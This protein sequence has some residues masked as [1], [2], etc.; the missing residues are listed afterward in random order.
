[1]GQKYLL[2]NLFTILI[3]FGIYTGQLEFSVFLTILLSIVLVIIRFVL[4]AHDKV[5]YNVFVFFI[6]VYGLLTLFTHIELIKNPYDDFFVHNDAAWSFYKWT[7]DEVVPLEWSQLIEGTLLNPAFYEYFLAELLFGTIAKIAVSFGI[8]DVRL[9]LRCLCFVMGA[10]INTIIA[11]M[12]IKNKKSPKETFKNILCFGCISYLYITS[13]VFSR[14][15]FVCLTYAAIGYVILI[16]KCSFR[17]VKLLLLSFCAF[18]GRPENG[19][20]A[21]VFVIAYYVSLRESKIIN[22]LLTL[23]ILLFIAVFVQYTSFVSDSMESLQNFEDLTKD[24]TGG[25]FQKVYS[26]PFPINKIAMVIYMLLQPLPM[27]KY[28][29]G[30][31][32]SWFTLPFVLSPYMIFLVIVCCIWFIIKRSSINKVVSYYIMT[33]I[34]GFCLITFVSPDLRRSF[35]T[36]PGLFGAYCLIQNEI[37]RT[38]INFAKKTIWPVLLITSMFFQ[39]Y[40]MTK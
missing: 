28:I 21:I 33:S 23:L 9:A 26:L 24:N 37:P 17:F 7:M 18:G 39:I 2:F 34:L 40:I 1:M 5:V 20:F 36:I 13:A 31:G 19:V 32:N 6:L 10:F 30:D 14:D 22:V 15:I 4:H 38:Y 11:D 29:L 27:Q 25:V 16:P 12:L 35:A 3:I 8:D